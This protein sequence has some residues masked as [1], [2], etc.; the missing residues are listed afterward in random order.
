MHVDACV[1]TLDA[2]ATLK[3]RRGLRAWLAGAAALAA[4][5]ALFV[6]YATGTSST[7]GTFGVITYE[8]DEPRWADPVL[9]IT[10]AALAL[11]AALLWA[12]RGPAT[13]VVGL[14]LFGLGLG[15]VALA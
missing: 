1:M 6:S 2:R 9:F 10:T 15:S 4:V 11:A 12:A 13:L 14:A 3:R 8:L 7:A 5:G